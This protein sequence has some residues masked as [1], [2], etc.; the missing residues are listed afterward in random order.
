MEYLK[1][2]ECNGL[3]YPPRDANV[4][5][6][7]HGI[8]VAGRS[9][10]FDMETLMPKSYKIY[11]KLESEYRKKTGGRAHILHTLTD[12]EYRTVVAEL[13]RVIAEDPCDR[14]WMKSRLKSY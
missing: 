7:L 1:Y 11:W 13:E 14:E 8:V 3:W 12:A 4:S 9:V 2:E 6:I 10:R 5:E